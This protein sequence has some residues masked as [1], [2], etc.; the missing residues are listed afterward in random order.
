MCGIAF[1]NSDKIDTQSITK[2]LIILHRGPDNHILHFEN[3]S[4]SHII[5]LD[6]S[7][8][9]NMPM[10]DKS[11]RYVIVFNGEIYNFKELKKQFKIYQTNTDTEVLLQIIF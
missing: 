3:F 7:E 5:F 4:F 11:G 8:N 2:L 9:G 6:L 10:T 1:C